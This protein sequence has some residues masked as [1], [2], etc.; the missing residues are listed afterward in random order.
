MPGL[1]IPTADPA[2][3]A[4]LIAV[5]LFGLL[6]STHCVGMCGGIVAALN[7]GRPTIPVRALP[8]VVH[9]TRGTVVRQL[10]YN[11][12]R[13]TSYALAGGLAGAVGSASWLAER[14]L[15]VQQLAFIIGS[16][17][18][19]M[20]GLQM[21]GVSAVSTALES[22]GRWIWPIFKP[23]AQ[24][25]LQVQGL[26][27]A[28]LAG[29]AWGW[30]PCGMVYGV[31]ALAIVSGTV[32]SG[33]AVMLAFGLGTLPTLVGLGWLGGRL[34]NRVDRRGL[35]KLIGGLIVLFAVA[36]LARMDPIARI[37]QFGEFCLS[38]V[39]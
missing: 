7:R 27:G 4:A 33:A 2:G 28:A 35:Q 31:L 20:I 6:G 25:S 21:I 26:K 16:L 11:S 36:G 8:G 39:R 10:A 22:A 38:W 12:G 29:F 15:P 32:L 37:H 14:V 13:L 19:L 9:Q 24:S 3:I 30:V 34:G 5:F 18:M 1:S 23:L 17:V